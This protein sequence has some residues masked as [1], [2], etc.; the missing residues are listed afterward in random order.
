MVAL[1]NL[2]T[3]VNDFFPLLGYVASQILLCKSG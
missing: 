2:L 1:I 3:S